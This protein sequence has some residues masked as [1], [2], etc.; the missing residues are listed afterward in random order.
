M[1]LSPILALLGFLLIPLQVLLRIVGAVHLLLVQILSLLQGLPVALLP[2]PVA[3][4][5]LL[6][7]L[8]L[9]LSPALPLAT[10]LLP[11]RE[12]FLFVQKPAMSLTHLHISHPTQNTSS[13]K[14]L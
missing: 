1:F 7:F 13:P 8:P 5:P 14:G 2:L 12:P 10:P 11:H 9:Y 3:L 4:L 6:V